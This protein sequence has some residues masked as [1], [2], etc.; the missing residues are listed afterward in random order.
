MEDFNTFRMRWAVE[1]QKKIKSGEVKL[2][3]ELEAKQPER[4]NKPL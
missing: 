2:L 1:R 4:Q 3:T